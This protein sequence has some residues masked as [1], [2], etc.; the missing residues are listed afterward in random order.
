MNSRVELD[1]IT[2]F[3]LLYVAIKV[4]TQTVSFSVLYT[5]SS[6]SEEHLVHFETLV[7]F[8]SFME[9]K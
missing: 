4:Q 9:D 2:R 5:I 7:S 8:D 1:Y 3:V 6:K